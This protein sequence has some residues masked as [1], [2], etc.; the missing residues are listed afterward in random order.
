MDGGIVNE[1]IEETQRR[2]GEGCKGRKERVS[3]RD[4][5]RKKEAYQSGRGFK[6]K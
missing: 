3:K 4:K 1:N 2:R 5:G 6:K